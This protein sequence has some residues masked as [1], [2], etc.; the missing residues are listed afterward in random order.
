MILVRRAMPETFIN[1]TDTMIIPNST[2]DKV[3]II[4]TSF[5]L[6]L[7]NIISDKLFCFGYNKKRDVF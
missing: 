1:S 5:E 7:V 2:M 3:D 4:V 6:L